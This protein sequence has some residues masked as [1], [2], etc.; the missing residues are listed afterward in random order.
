MYL[1]PN[2]SNQYRYIKL[3]NGLRVLIV[4]DEHAQKSAAALAVNVGHFDDPSDREGLAHY[5]EHMLFLGTEKYPKTGEFQAF[6]S[7]HGGN[8]NAWTGTEHT[9]Y[10][11]D[12]S[13]NAFERSL[14]RFSQFFIAPLFNP[15]A[16]EKERQA[17]ESEYRLKLK[18]DMRRLFQVHKEVVN[19][20]H[21][22]SKF[23]VGNIETLSDREGSSIRDEI[24]E[25]YGTH[26]SADLMTLAVVGPQELDELERWVEDL[27]S[28]IQN[29]H[30]FGKKV[31]VPL[32]NP[33]LPSCYVQVEPEKDSRKLVLAFTLPCMDEHYASKP[34]SYFAHLLGYEGEGSLMLYLKELGWVNGLAAGG[35]MSGS[36]FREF[37]VSC[38]LTQEGLD[39]V[40]DIVEATFAYIKLIID[41][42][43]D[44][45]R[46][47]EKQAVLESA[48]QFQEAA[49]PLDLVSH[50]VMNL[51]HYPEEDVV[52]GDY[53]MAHFDTALLGKVAEYFTVDNMRLTLIAKGVECNKVA[54]WYDTPYSVKRFTDEQTSCWKEVA[55]NP[56]LTLP[57]V[58][59]YI[60]YDLTPQ[61]LE[62]NETK[63]KLIQDLP[64]FRL[65]HLQE[66]DFRVPK[67]VLYLAI[68]SPHAVSTPRKIVQTRLCVE[69]F[70]DALVKETYQA[71]IAGMGYNM[72]AHQGGVTLTLSG[73]SQ[74]QP[75][76]LSVIL[77]RFANRDF[78]SSRFDTIKQQMLRNWK[79]AAKDRPVSQLFNAMTGLLQPNNPPYPELIEA[80]ESIEMD[81]LP[82]FVDTILNELHVELFVY[83]DW[84]Q[85]QS[86]EL[87]ETIKNALR[88]KDQRYEESLRPLVMLGSNGTFQREVQCN[89][90]DSAIVIYYQSPEIDPR[91]I[92][93]YS[94]AN[95][96][97]S[98][99]F[100]HEI[101]TKQQLGYMV[102]TGNL[103][104]N[105]HPGLVLYVQSPNAAPIDLLSA[106][107]EFLNAFYMVLLELNEYQ[108]Q[109]SKKG[110]WSQI[111]T[112][113]NNLRGRAQRL[114]VAIGN[115]DHQFNQRDKVLEELK[116][117]TRSE[118]IRFVVSVLKPRTANRLIMH[119]KGNEHQDDPCL[120]EGLEIGSV[121][122]FQLRPKDVE[123]G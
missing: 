72:Y 6:I 82:A 109:S 77:T 61:A 13:P 53:K 52:Y 50:L 17:V 99:T 85:S 27:F 90:A 65:W 43:F 31:T 51:H 45:W 105:R 64:G 70:L 121:E 12:V 74:K 41:S 89:Q 22:F 35:G 106:I 110:L 100:F 73:F 55:L 75:Q 60:C 80:L 92:A 38:T 56:E 69:L 32:T 87:A 9:C 111:A 33:E 21:P 91:S 29:R 94:L 107:D 57:E 40:D 86:I 96:L 101:R 37:S 14:K 42:G 115:K 2:D 15:D 98:A 58:N 66:K 102:G 48:F 119:S 39:H 30:L 67:G 44:E 11:F 3:N 4:R 1:S 54:K 68:D 49:R 114:W 104:L 24:I 19:P 120:N 93:L 8:N 112:P 36:N 10:F 122:E 103:P 84:N 46:Y 118:M 116:T 63:P 76:L 5:L 23:S 16:L 83:G 78:R 59:P 26:Y 34:L 7:Q 62:G 71:E 108:W 47:K 81:E 28:P 117:L 20:E 113:D 79:N 25:F 95:H 123:L 18:D 88:V 97:M